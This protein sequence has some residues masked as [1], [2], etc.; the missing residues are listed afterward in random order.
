MA[1]YMPYA[2]VTLISRAIPRIDGFKPVQR[3][4]VYTMNNMGLLKGGRAKSQRI[5]GQV[6][7]YHPHGDSSIYEAAVLMT[8]GYE[9]LNLPYIESK[10]SFGKVYSRDLKYSA[11]RYTEM[12]LAPIAGELFDGINE[13]A[14]DMVDNFDNTLKEPKILPVKFPNILVNTSAGV[15]VGF[16]C[17]IPSFSLKGVCESTIGIINGTIDSPDKLADVI[18]NPEFT[19]GGYL[20][21]S[22]EKLV[23]LCKTGK[24]T[25]MISGDVEIYYDRIVITEIPYCTTAEAIME[26]LEAAV[27]EK[28]I[29]GIKDIRD[30]IGLAG[31]RLVVEVKSGYNSREVLQEI[32]RLTKLRTTISFRTRVVVD[33]RCKEMGIYDLLQYWIENRQEQIRRVREFRANKQ[34]TEAHLLEAWEKIFNNLPEVVHMISS[35]TEDNARAILMSKYGLDELQTDYL[36]DMRIRLITKDRAQ[37]SINKLNDLRASI[38]EL[39]SI[40]SDK[41]KRYKIIIEEQEEILRKYSKESKTKMAVELSEEVLKAKKPEISDEQT[42]VIVTDTGYIRR[43]T[44]LK[45]LTGTYES[46]NG[47]KEVMRFNIKNNQHILI[48]DR[49]GTVHKV[50]V[51]DIDASSR[52]NMTDK[53]NEIA[54]IEKISDI[55]WIDGCGDYKGYFNLV[56]PNGR[57]TRV[58]YSSA[59]GNRSQYKSLYKEV[60]PGQYWATT[61][62]KFFMITHRNKASYCDLTNLGLF[63]NR[64]AF[65]VARVS[66][67]DYFVK[68]HPEKD[69]PNIKAIDLDKYKKDYTVAIGDDPLVFDPELEERVN[70]AMR[71]E[72]ERLNKKPPEKGSLEDVQTVDEALGLEEGT[73]AAQQAEI[74]SMQE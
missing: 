72:I 32:C 52:A 19:T 70:E 60:K 53:I 28:R 9:G 63:N 24:G 48:F 51:D 44:S 46:K 34:K 15:A 66:S 35:N 42:V 6:M 26:D 12:K 7:A 40:C 22:R 20:H 29:N 11:P 67:G 65:K 56:Y 45:D 21:S 61:E 64:C 33:E 2:K 39:E 50:L 49:F 74:D 54:G 73:A 10:G 57:G 1:E 5:N 16:S 38:A 41:N 62:N 30:E 71:Q 13:N 69:V 43:L 4:I 27:K 37:K 25:F 55:I 17:Y 58:M 31:L 8:T 68:L 36:M 14:V 3:R 47:D 18:G 23:N 59:S